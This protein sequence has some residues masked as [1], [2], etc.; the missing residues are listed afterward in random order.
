MD[1]FGQKSFV[2]QMTSL[3]FKEQLAKEMPSIKN[4]VLEDYQ[5]ELDNNE[6]LLLTDRSQEIFLQNNLIHSQTAIIFKKFYASRY[7]ELKYEKLMN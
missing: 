4:K 6:E 3:F 2:R 5:K 7:N 1:F